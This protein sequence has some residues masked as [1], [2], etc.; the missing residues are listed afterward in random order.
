MAISEQQIAEKLY[1][2]LIGVADTEYPLTTRNFNEEP[3]QSYYKVLPDQIWAQ[4]DSIPNTAPV[5]GDLV[6]LGVVKYFDLLQLNGISGS[7]VGFYHD[8]L[9]DAIPFNYGDG[10]SYFYSLFASDG[11][12]PIY[13]G[14]GDWIVDVE[15]GVLTFYSTPSVTVGYS[16]P[17]RIRFYKY[18]GTKGLSSG[19]TSGTGAAIT[20]KDPVTLAST[21]NITG[22][23]N[24]N[25]GFTYLPE[26][27]DG[28]STSTLPEAGR[29]LL[30]NQSNLQQNGIFQISGTTLIRATDSDATSGETSINDY[31]FVLSGDTLTASSWI[32][33]TTT[34]VDITDINPYVDEQTWKLFSSGVQYTAD[35]N[36]L[37]L[38]GN[39]FYVE[40]DEVTLGDSG[41]QQG[42]D[43]LKIET[44][45]LS[46]INTIPDLTSDILV[47][48]GYTTALSG[49]TGNLSA[50]IVT[51]SGWSGN[52]ASSISTNITNISNLSGWT[53]SIESRVTI[54]EN[55]ITSNDSDIAELSGCTGN[56][57]SNIVSLSGWT[58]SINT[59][60][61]T[62]VIDIAALSG[63]TGNL[64]SNI[65]SLSGW[66]SV[67][68]ADIIINA[69]NISSNTG[70]INTNITNI[71]NLSGWTGSIESRVTINE[72]DILELSGATVDLSGVAG[73]GLTYTSGDAKLNVKVD[74]WTIK[75]TTNSGLT[76]PIIWMQV[77]S[78]AT[79]SGVAGSTGIALNYDPVGFVSAYINGIEYRVNPT[80]ASS[81]T[82]IPFYFDTG[83]PAQGSILWFNPV[84]AGFDVVA[85]TDYIVIKY[86][87]LMDL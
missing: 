86:S 61:E 16:S 58:G 41:L 75:I 11:T 71:S 9:K 30:K 23:T 63:W 5:L 85:G 54:N 82:N 2:K 72:S 48:S 15:S 46:D 56:L 27:I 40:L 67:L 76:T 28:I 87:Y 22:Y 36:A 3:Y 17:P 20:V 6:T 79:I 19:S 25:S 7:D 44:S 34:A 33:A 73:S 37:K 81:T 69:N 77:T 12:T 24:G 84:E 14:D 57:A 38:L 65:I 53:G 43:G 29:I 13:F 55:D 45:I 32:L 70:S 59:Q 74:D 78:S 18:V 10:T 64:A 50:D 42:V 52:L 60:V 80:T 35:G 66:S 1:K 83:I 31:V 62:N 47:V 39:Q 49:W 4:A 51:L 26:T 68:A 21:V 8:D